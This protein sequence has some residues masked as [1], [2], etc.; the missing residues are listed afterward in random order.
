MVNIPS[1]QRLFY[2]LEYN[3]SI[4]E[5]MQVYQIC[6]D[7]LERRTIMNDTEFPCDPPEIL[8]CRFGWNIFFWMF[9]SIHKY[10]FKAKIMDNLCSIMA[11]SF[12]FGMICHIY[13][14]KWRGKKSVYLFSV[15]MSGF[16]S[17]NVRD[18]RSQDPAF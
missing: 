7:Q 1:N 4:E 2:N 6:E 5:Q 18:P 8:F 12:Q 10:S 17:I 14:L 9:N 13:L 16:S 3:W 11:Y 15:E